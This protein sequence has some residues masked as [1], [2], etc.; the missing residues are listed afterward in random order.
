[1][2]LRLSLT[3]H[4]ATL[5]LHPFPEQDT[6]RCYRILQNKTFNFCDFKL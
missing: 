2:Q 4:Q 6:E 5:F 3:A 1:M